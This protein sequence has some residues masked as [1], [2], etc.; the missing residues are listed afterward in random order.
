MIILIFIV[1]YFQIGMLVCSAALRD[2]DVS[3]SLLDS[4]RTLFVLVVIWFWP[5]ICWVGIVKG[6]RKI[7]KEIIKGE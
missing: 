7:I 6:I 1:V 3:D 5:V 2:V 4:D